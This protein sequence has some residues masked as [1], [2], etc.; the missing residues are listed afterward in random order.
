MLPD[1]DDMAMRQ[2]LAH[3]QPSPHDRLAARI[4]AHA[5][6]Q[7]Q[8]QSLL[9]ILSRA[10]SQWDYGLQYKSAALAAFA[11]LGLLSAQLNAT[12]APGLD[13]GSVVMADPTWTEEL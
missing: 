12:H 10:F 13:L 2:M 7:P 9:R 8:K 11:V 4:V 5:T 3:Y 1:N 6:A